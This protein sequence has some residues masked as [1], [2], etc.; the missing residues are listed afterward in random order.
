MPNT[1]CWVKAKNG[2]LTFIVDLHGQTSTDG[3]EMFGL[4]QR[5]IWMKTQTQILC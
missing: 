5:P 1:I 3:P 4:I 2:F